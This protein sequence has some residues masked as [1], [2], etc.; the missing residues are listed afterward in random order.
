MAPVA[1]MQSGFCG[2]ASRR[3]PFRIQDGRPGRLVLR[4]AYGVCR[5]LVIAL[6]VPGGASTAAAQV[7]ADT[8]IPPGLYYS[9]IVMLQE[10]R[11]RDALRNFES[12]YRSAIRVGAQRWVDSICYLTMQ[13]EALYAMGRLDQALDSYNAALQLSLAYPDWLNYVQFPP[14]LTPSTQ[15]AFQ[16]VPWQGRTRTSRFANYPEEMLILLG[17]VEWARAFQEG[18]VAMPAKLKPINVVE[19][20]R[21]NALAMRRRMELLGPLAPVDPMTKDLFNLWSRRPGPPNHWSQCWI[22]L[23]LGLAMQADGRIDE[24]IPMLTRSTTAAGQYDHPMTAYA[25]IELG[26]LAL[27]RGDF[28]AAQGFFH[29]ATFPAVVYPDAAA[30]E[31]AFRW[32]ALAHLLSGAQGPYPPAAPAAAWARTKRLRQVQASLALSAAE[33]QAAAGNWTAVGTLLDEAQSAFARTDLA[34]S[35]PAD[36]WNF[37]RAVTLLHAGNLKDGEAALSAAL[38]GMRTRSLW[39]F[40]L[41]RLSAIYT[42]GRITMRGPITPK[43]AMELY[44]ILLRDPGRLDWAVDPLESLTV[45]ATPHPTLFEQWFRIAWERNLADEALQISERAK[46]HR[47]EAALPLGGRLDAVR[48]LIAAPEEE[49]SNAARVERTNVLGKYPALAAGMRESQEMYAKLRAMPFPPPDNAASQTLGQALDQWM[50]TNSGMEAVL[51]SVAVSRETAGEPY[52]PV[53]PTKEIQKRLPQG[54][55]LLSFFAIG[56]DLYGFLHTQD[57]YEAWRVR[58]GLAPV[59]RQLTTLLQQLGQYDANREFSIKEAGD[60]AW[61]NT[62]ESILNAITSGSKADLAGEFGELV[63]VPDGALWHLPFEL[64]QVKADDQ[65]VPLIAKHPIRYSPTAGLAVTP[66]PGPGVQPRTGVYLGRLY[67]QEDASAAQRRFD[68]L[69]QAVPACVPLPAAGTAV[70][71]AVLAPLFDNLVI[72][73]DMENT[74]TPLDW[75]PLPLGSAGNSLA[76]WLALPWQAPRVFVAPGFHTVAESAFKRLGGVPSGQ[77]LFLSLTTL[78]ACGTRTV[79]IS[80]WRTGGESSL[81]LVREFLQEHRDKGAAEA[82]R[83]AVLLTMSTP[84]DPAL[85]P[86]VQ[87]KPP[88]Q[89]LR[90]E[91]PF[92]WGGYLL[93]AP[94]EIASDAGSLPGPGP[95]ENAAPPAAP[96]AA[97]AD[98]G[99]GPGAGADAATGDAGRDPPGDNPPPPE[100]QQAR[101]Q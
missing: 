70:N 59:A 77:E 35:R 30:L 5:L 31:E 45:T 44:A 21:C 12:C 84:L 11:V 64:L 58:G 8:R 82:F 71:G 91:N 26:R 68:A 17:N 54:T 43:T 1:V 25:L 51:R 89:P 27:A 33:L 78:A 72:L 36:R 101:Q 14:Q 34:A 50:A 41:G 98:A 37:L 52:P 66:S 81:N 18:G 63:I 40:Q 79:L 10:G 57:R 9:G 99:A 29:E 49:L 65:R 19:I 95:G 55:V 46:R 75:A 20:L 74:T 39:L 15:A 88:D 97:G 60:T 13:G 22:D 92:F 53:L 93:A 94:G 67:P 76:D 38:N 80:R 42:S 3:S 6:I 16:S 69:A 47:F 90:M 28:A 96:G 86:R 73:A 56:N 100:E 61:K 2:D 7:A 83:R 62:A 24:A 32:A 87:K 48:R 4:V 23:L 85:E